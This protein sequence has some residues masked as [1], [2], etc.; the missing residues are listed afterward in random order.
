MNKAMRNLLCLV[1][2]LCLPFVSVSSAQQD[3]RTDV[4]IVIAI[5]CS[6]SINRFEYML[7]ME[8][9]AAALRDPEVRTAIQQGRHGRIGLMMTQ[10]SHLSSQVVSIPWQ[11]VQTDDQ[12]E[13]FASLVERTPR[14][15][16]EGGTSISAALDHAQLA[17]ESAPFAGD[18]HVIN[19]VSDGENNSGERVEHARDRAVLRGTT[20]NVAA[21]VGEFHW[22][23]HY[24]RNRVMGGEGAFVIEVA[25]YNDLV[26]GFKKKLIREIRGDALI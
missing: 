7:Q 23:H 14:K 6:W 15:P 12:L 4:N 21:V 2:I 8:G 5:D 18:R 1:A 17:L 19:L 9:I 22:L 3:Q 25:N 26:N 13:R 11:E 20:I 10:W 16:V 24:M